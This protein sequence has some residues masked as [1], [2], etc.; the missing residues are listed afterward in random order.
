MKARANLCSSRS[1]FFRF[2]FLVLCL[3]SSAS[4][5]E[6]LAP[7]SSRVWQTE[8]GLPKNSVRSIV[9]TTDGYLW[10]AAQEELVR[11]DGAQFETIPMP[12]IRPQATQWISDLCATRDGALIVR[13]AEA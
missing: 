8:D 1:R 10:F 12:P 7:Y 9:Q 13:A 3:V 5:A 4:F 11:F 2:L 6:M